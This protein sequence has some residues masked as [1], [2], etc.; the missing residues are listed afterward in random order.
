MES[1]SLLSQPKATDGIEGTTQWIGSQF[2]MLSKTPEDYVKDGW[3]RYDSDFANKSDKDVHGMLE[4]E[5]VNDLTRLQVQPTMH[6]CYR[7]FVVIKGEM[8]NHI[9]LDKDGVCI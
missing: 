9:K 7:R 1:P 5:I 8:E 2:S 3:A 6:E 4:F